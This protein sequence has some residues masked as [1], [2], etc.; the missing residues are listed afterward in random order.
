MRGQ[1]VSLRQF[2]RHLFEKS[3]ALG[4]YEAKNSSEL[5]EYAENTFNG[6]D[7]RIQDVLR[8]LGPTTAMT[9]RA[10]RRP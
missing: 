4:A 7:N 5:F 6:V 10:S 3:D 9:I 8:N 1:T 2:Y